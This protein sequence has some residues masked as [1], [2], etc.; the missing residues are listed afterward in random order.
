MLNIYISVAYRDFKY[1]YLLITLYSDSATAGV[2][3]TDLEFA[4]PS[5][6]LSALH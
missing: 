1:H 5:N 2:H 6:R 3:H 4:A